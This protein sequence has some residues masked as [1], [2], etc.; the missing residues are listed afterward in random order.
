MTSASITERRTRIKSATFATLLE[1]VF[2]IQ[3]RI[4]AHERF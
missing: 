1:E 2:G 3:E 4:L